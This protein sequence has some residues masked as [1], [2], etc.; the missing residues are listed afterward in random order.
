MYFLNFVSQN[1]K[2]TSNRK[3]PF[4]TNS[5]FKDLNNNNNNTIFILKSTYYPELRL[6]T[7]GFLQCTPITLILMICYYLQCGIQTIDSYCNSPSSFT[8]TLCVVFFVG[9]PVY[10]L[11]YSQASVHAV[12]YKL[13]IMAPVPTRSV[14]H[15]MEHFPRA[16]YKPIQT[17]QIHIYSVNGT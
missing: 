6:L 12:V 13:Y 4:K 8:C 3:V 5:N 10:I 1:I 9:S 11:S 16:Q 17:L 14:T 2:L 15:N 7:P